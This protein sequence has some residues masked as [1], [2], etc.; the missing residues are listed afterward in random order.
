M[1]S[2]GSVASSIETVSNAV[3]VSG[4]NVRHSGRLL[5][6]GQFPV[7]ALNSVVH[8]TI[9]WETFTTPVGDCL[10]HG[11]IRSWLYLQMQK[12]K[13]QRYKGEDFTLEH[14]YEAIF[15]YT[16]YRVLSEMLRPLAEGM[17][18]FAEFDLVP[19][20]SP[21]TTSLTRLLTL[22]FGRKYINELGKLK[23]SDISRIVFEGIRKSADCSIRKENLLCQEFH[24]RQGGYLPGYFLVKGIRNYLVFQRGLTKLLDGDL[25]FFCLKAVFFGDLQFCSHATDP[26]EDFFLG[27]KEEGHSDPKDVI[28]RMMKRFQELL[29]F[30][31]HD[32]DQEYIDRIEALLSGST[33]W[34]WA[35]L[36]TSGTDSDNDKLALQVQAWIEAPWTKVTDEEHALASVVLSNRRYLC[37]A[38]YSAF[39]KVNSHARCLIYADASM[40]ME[41]IVAATPAIVGSAEGS[42]EGSVEIFLVEQAGSFGRIVGVAHLG[43]KCVAKFDVG[44]GS[45]E[46]EASGSEDRLDDSPCFW[47]AAELQ[48]IMNNQLIALS[49]E[50]P[51]FEHYMSQVEQITEGLHEFYGREVYSNLLGGDYDKLINATSLINLLDDE[52]CR[53]LS[54][55]VRVSLS[56]A[57]VCTHDVLV[58]LLAKENTEFEDF[59]TSL[60]RIHKN[61]GVPLASRRGEVWWFN[62]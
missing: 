50:D 19:R 39:V 34:S 46:Q 37:L 6:D 16:R 61:F 47:F 57:G 30:V 33:Q 51:L 1:S 2:V 58:D 23:I 25:F 44:R 53:F 42:G 56:C 45:L 5:L 32:L 60:K 26:E 43:G 13:D 35:R 31:F 28:N 54:L 15:D 12:R 52:A 20:D 62:F 41:S 59:Q 49:N 4:L 55:S 9:H 10:A 24:T 17:A 21:V 18:I 14:E 3:F 36:Q 22:Q 8:E 29:N 27:P 7:T 11:F 40:N 38:S 48:G